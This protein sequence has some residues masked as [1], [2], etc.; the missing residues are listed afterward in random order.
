VAGE[1][2]EFPGRRAGDR[3]EPDTEPDTANGHGSDDDGNSNEREAN[4]LRELGGGH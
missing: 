2:E 1:S 4:A 3:G